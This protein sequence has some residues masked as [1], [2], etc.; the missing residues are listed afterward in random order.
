MLPQCLYYVDKHYN[1]QFNHDIIIFYHGEKYDDPEYQKMIQQINSKTKIQFHKLEYKLPSHIK[2]TDLFYHK[3]QIPYVAKDFP[4][5]RE[6]YLYAN[7]FWNNFMNYPELKQYQYLIRID[8]DS[9]FKQPI[10]QN[11]F[12]QLQQSQQLCGTG[13]TWNHV[14]H[15]G[16]NFKETHF[17]QKPPDI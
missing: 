10:T 13:Y 9:W 2:E 11:I 5:N 7:Y 4:K 8:D 1:H 6:G 14:H 15:R 12:E 3:T 16:F 17:I